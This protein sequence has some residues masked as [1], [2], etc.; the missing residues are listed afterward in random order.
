MWLTDGQEGTDQRTAT[1]RRISRMMALN[2]GAGGSYGAL[3]LG[4]AHAYRVRMISGES[5]KLEP[6]DVERPQR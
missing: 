1:P 3:P 2:R 4:N 5:L 6:Q